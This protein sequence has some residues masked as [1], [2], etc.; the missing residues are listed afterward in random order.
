MPTPDGVP[1]ERHHD[2]APPGAA[3]GRPDRIGGRYDALHGPVPFGRRRRRACG[4][5][6]ADRHLVPPGTGD[7][8]GNGSGTGP[9]H[10][11]PPRR[12]RG[13]RGRG[14]GAAARRHRHPRARVQHPSRGRAHLGA[15]AGAGEGPADAV[16]RGRGRRVAARG[17]Q[18]PG[19]RRAAAG[20]G[21]LRRHRPGG[22][23][24]RQGVRHGRCRLRSRWP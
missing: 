19:C 14:R 1:D 5:R 13:R 17:D 12:R 11:R 8:G 9:P 24:A 7:G 3:S 16:G 6:A 15:A 21:W 23:A 10:H 4:R 20:P 2:S 22:R 18:G